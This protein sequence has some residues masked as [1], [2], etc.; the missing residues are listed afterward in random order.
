MTSPYYNN[1]SVGTSVVEKP[2][3]HDACD[4]CGESGR[5]GN[6]VTSAIFG[7]KVFFQ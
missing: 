2:I 4:E 5:D 3:P 6:P 7:N 1:I